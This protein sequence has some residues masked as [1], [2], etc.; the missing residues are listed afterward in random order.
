MTQYIVHIYR[1]MR[2]SYT[3]IEADTPVAAAAALLASL[4]AILPYAEN[5]AHSLESLKDSPEA[6]AEADHAWKAVEAAQ[7]AIAQ[8]TAAGLPSSAS[9][10]LPPRPT[11]RGRHSHGRH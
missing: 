3:D 11:Q 7:T 6:D 9:S 4:D 5:E 10:A 8:A 2:L 1:E